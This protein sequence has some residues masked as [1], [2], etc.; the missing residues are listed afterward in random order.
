MLIM[1]LLVLGIGFVEYI[2][3]LLVDVL[4]ALGEV[5]CFASFRLD[6]NRIILSS[7]KWHGYVNGT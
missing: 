5:V 7:Y 4:N 3:K 1:A 2:M 6:T